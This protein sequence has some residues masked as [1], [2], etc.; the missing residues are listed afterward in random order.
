MTNEPDPTLEFDIRPGVVAMTSCVHC[1]EL[2]GQHRPFGWI[3]VSVGFL[4]CEQPRPG[5]PDRCEAEP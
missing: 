1:G 5:S 4:T 3:H 2:I